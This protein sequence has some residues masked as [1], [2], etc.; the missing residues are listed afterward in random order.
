MYVCVNEIW[1]SWFFFNGT[2]IKTSIRVHTKLQWIPQFS[3]SPSRHNSRLWRK[4][5]TRRRKVIY[6][7][8]FFKTSRR[9]FFVFFLSIF[10]LHFISKKSF[11][12]QNYWFT[13]HGMYTVYTI[14]YILQ[15]RR[16]KRQRPQWPRI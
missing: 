9:F 16:L 12:Q 14:L 3:S 2:Q 10:L 4:K 7:C 13:S 11:D 15:E 8:V 1:I 5:K 6:L